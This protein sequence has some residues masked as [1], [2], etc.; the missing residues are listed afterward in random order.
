MV[1]NGIKWYQL[2]TRH[3]YVE[4]SFWPIVRKVTAEGRDWTALRTGATLVDAPGVNDDNGARDRVVKEYLKNA[5]SVW[6]VSNIKRAVNDRTAKDMLS[7]S[8]RRQLLMDGQYGQIVFVA[9]QSDDLHASEL[10][11]NLGLDLP[12][13]MPLR[14]RQGGGASLPRSHQSPPTTC[15]MT[16]RV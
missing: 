7:E 13:D 9:T 12:P 2:G 15:M 14:E 6:I 1:S 4:G 5:D 8:F 11:D 10:R 3:H 16:R